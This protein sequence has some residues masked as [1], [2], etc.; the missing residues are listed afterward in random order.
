MEWTE[1]ESLLRQWDHDKHRCHPNCEF[2]E[3][4]VTVNDGQWTGTWSEFCK[5]NRDS[6]SPDELDKI[7]QFLM[8][9]EIV[10]GGGGASEEFTIEK[11]PQS[12]S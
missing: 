9:G 7:S 3:M 11:A 10:D 8:D 1:E 2:C 12:T 5:E 6:F 4:I